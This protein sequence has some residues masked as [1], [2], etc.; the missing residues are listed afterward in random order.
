VSD[1]VVLSDEN[2][3]VVLVETSAR[4]GMT[5][6]LATQK[7]LQS[8]QGGMFAAPA[9]LLVVSPDSTF[10]WDQATMQNSLSKPKWQVSTSKL[11]GTMMPD[12]FSLSDESL[13][14]L[15]YGWLT[16]LTAPIKRDTEHLPEEVVQSGLLNAIRGGTVHS[17]TA[18]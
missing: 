14:L 17:K 9:Y 5:A 8:L 6:E 13:Q 16:Q 4:T 12:T 2:E 1:L 7:A 10:I 18:A 15:L 11:L 3:P